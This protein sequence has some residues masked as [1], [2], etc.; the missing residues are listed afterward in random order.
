V[1]VLRH[2]VVSPV[3]L[4]E[5]VSVPKD[6]LAKLLPHQPSSPSASSAAIDAGEDCADGDCDH[7]TPASCGLSQVRGGV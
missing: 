3:D 5:D 6:V 1:N 2:N 4:A 7:A